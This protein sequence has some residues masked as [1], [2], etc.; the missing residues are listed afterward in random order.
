[1][2][3]S[4]TTFRLR[5]LAWSPPKLVVALALGC[6]SLSAQN[7]RA[8]TEGDKAA[9]D[10]LF[11]A[12]RDL[13]EAK[14]YESACPK[15]RDSHALDPAVGTL[16]NLGLCYKAA[17]KTASAWTSYREAAALARSS[18]Q[19]DREELA[20]SEIKALEAILTKLVIE[21][22]P[23]AADVE[24]LKLT[25]DG[26]E[27]PRTMWG[28]PVAVDP[29]AVVVEASAPG[30]NSRSATIQVGGE[31][32]TVSFRVMALKRIATPAPVPTG[33]A[34]APKSETKPAEEPEQE[35]GTS[36]AA[37]PKTTNSTP[38]PQAKS[39]AVPWIVGGAGLLVAGGGTAALFAGREQTNSALELCTSIDPTSGKYVCSS[40][41][42]KTKR[43]SFSQTGALLQGVGWATIGV[44]A[45]AIATSVVWLTL[46]KP[47]KE[48]VLLVEPIVGKS[49]WALSAS[50]RF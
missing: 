14:D 10:A 19:S 2:Y 49:V 33:T 34:A 45:A 13:M 8:D 17:G 41:G 40:D 3:S 43:D 35:T 28:L 39:S 47:A 31:G 22:T 27:V 50:G 20:R 1:M 44:G 11:D 21:V 23:E 7:A 42:E 24:G 26:S 6:V 29:G 48:S 38:Q 9:A 25:R 18:G 15:F 16:L 12:A 46:R 5:K 30:H 32:K 4:T 36:R 37:K